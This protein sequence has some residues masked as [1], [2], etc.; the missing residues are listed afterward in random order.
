MTTTRTVRIEA[1]AERVWELVSDLPGMGALSPE[2][3]G[4]SWRGGA[5]GAV[6]GARFRGRNR[7]GWRRWSTTVRVTRCVPG[8]SFAF[9]VTALGTPVSEWAYDLAPDG[10]GACTVT[11]TWYDRR[12]SW[13]K[14]AGAL[15][16]GVRERGEATAAAEIE[17][18]LAALT[19]A[20]EGSRSL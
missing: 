10:D 12:W 3:T 6:V 19:R 20:A 14:P 11:E 15:L 4:G 7:N 13:T 5:T 16:S 2:N 17:A 9:T 8:R 18:T 1:P